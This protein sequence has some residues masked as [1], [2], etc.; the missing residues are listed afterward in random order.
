MEQVLEFMCWSPQPDL[1]WCTRSYQEL[2]VKAGNPLLPFWANYRIVFEMS[3]GLAHF[4]AKMRSVLKALRIL[5][6]GGV[7]SHVKDL[8]V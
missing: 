1:N 7:N 8:V 3:Q 2:R 6:R 5:L 4:Y